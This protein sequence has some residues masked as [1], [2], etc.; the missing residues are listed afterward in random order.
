MNKKNVVIALAVIVIGSMGG[1]LALNKPASRT[2]S[3]VSAVLA[4]VTPAE[5]V[6]NSSG[7]VLGTVTNTDVVKIPSTLRPGKEDIATNA[8]IKV[9]KYLVNPENLTAP[10]VIVQVLG[11]T[12]GDQT[13]S[14]EESPTF[15]VGDR[16][17][18]FLNRKDD[19]TYTVYGWAQG[20]YTVDSNGIV[21]VG[22]EQ[23]YMKDVFGR[24]T[25]DLVTFSSQLDAIA[26]STSA[27]Q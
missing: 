12:I 16:V 14:A 23:T 25:M 6:K 3:D 4:K 7:V 21:G 10:E 18:V 13:M 8:T 27:L 26:K 2:V 24:D 5:L 11:G 19:K 1:A 9:E 22:D 20:K 15:K 17:V